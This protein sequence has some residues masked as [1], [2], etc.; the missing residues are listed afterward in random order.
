MEKG[1]VLMLSGFF[2]S[3]VEELLNFAKNYGFEKEFVYF[4][5]NW[6]AIKLK[7]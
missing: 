1:G 6:A 3:D 7:M 4:K 2:D 5:D